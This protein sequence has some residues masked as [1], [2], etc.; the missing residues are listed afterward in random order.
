[1]FSLVILKI[2]FNKVVLKLIFAFVFALVFVL[3][4]VVVNKYKYIEF[5]HFIDE[6]AN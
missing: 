2:S 6:A 3:V 4:V 5:A 1:M